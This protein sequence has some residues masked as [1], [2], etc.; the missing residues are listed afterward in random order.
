MPELFNQDLFN[1]GKK[2]TYG[3]IEYRYAYP[4]L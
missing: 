1:S 4:D 2:Y 3:Q